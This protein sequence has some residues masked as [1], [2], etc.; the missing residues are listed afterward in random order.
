[1]SP[2]IAQAEAMRR[3]QEEIAKIRKEQEDVPKKS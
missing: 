2:L 3:V 1:M